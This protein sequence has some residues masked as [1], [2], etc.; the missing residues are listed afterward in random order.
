M[1]LA[2]QSHLLTYLADPV[3]RITLSQSMLRST[4][5]PSTPLLPPLLL[6]SVPV[7]SPPAEEEEEEEEV[8]D[9]CCRVTVYPTSLSP[10][11]S[12]SFSSSPTSNGGDDADGKGVAAPPCC[13]TTLGFFCLCCLARAVTRQP[14][15]TRTPASRAASSSARVMV[16]DRSDTGNTRPSASV[17]SATPRPENQACVSAGLKRAVSAPSSSR[18][19]RG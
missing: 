4:L 2:Q 17:F 14:V 9:E 10:P 1:H 5:L 15:S 7:L 19:P 13:T 11:P 3:A 8:E 18:P 12:S 16:L 6:I